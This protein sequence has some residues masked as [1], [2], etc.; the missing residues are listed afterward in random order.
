M[1]KIDRNIYELKSEFKDFK[2]IVV[3]FIDSMSKPSNKDSLIG[4]SYAVSKFK[5]NNYIRLTFNLIVI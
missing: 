4:R 3:G 1:D 5:F 2:E